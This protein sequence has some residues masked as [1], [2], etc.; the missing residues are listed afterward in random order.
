MRK[1]IYAPLLSRMQT[2]FGWQHHRNKCKLTIMLHTLK[3]KLIVLYPN[4]SENIN[5]VERSG[6]PFWGIDT[7][8]ETWGFAVALASGLPSEIHS[9]FKG[10]RE[11]MVSWMLW[12]PY[13]RMLR[14]GGGSVKEADWAR[15]CRVLWNLWRI[16]VIL[17]RAVGCHWEILNRE[18]MWSGF[19]QIGGGG[20]NVEDRLEGAMG[21]MKMPVRW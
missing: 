9:M 6:G 16:R 5:Q 1:D 21:C 13:D 8:G 10:W 2:W 3:K 15:P 14:S 7:W 20:C 12:R 18:G 4:C 19:V 11:S 17:P